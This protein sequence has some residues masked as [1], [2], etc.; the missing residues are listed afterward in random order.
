MP[1]PGHVPRSPAAASLRGVKE[2]TGAR[3]LG[4]GEGD[5]L[6]QHRV[7]LAMLPSVCAETFS[8]VTAEFMEMQVPLAVFPI[9]APA[10]R[11]AGYGKGLVISRIDPAV[12]VQEILAFAAHP[13][14]VR[15]TR[16]ISN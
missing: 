13:D 15:A 16:A 10:E 11:V 2:N 12:A 9:G 7:T 5:L 1:N 3:L 14:G 8:F 4:V 6:E